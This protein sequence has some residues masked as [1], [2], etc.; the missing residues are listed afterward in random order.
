MKNSSHFSRILLCCSPMDMRK[1]ING[2]SEIVQ[3]HLGESPFDDCLF[4]FCNRRRDIIRALY[5]DRAGFC[6]WTKKLDREKFSW[7]RECPEKTKPVP[8]K[9]LDLLLDGVDV[10]KRHKKLDFTSAS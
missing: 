7:L 5:F 6:L 10:L 8:A 2:L 4:V 1:Q 9:D 3:D